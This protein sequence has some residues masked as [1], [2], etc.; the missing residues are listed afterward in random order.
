MDAPTLE[1]LAQ[2]LA[3]LRAR[4]ALLEAHVLAGAKA[5]K[6]HHVAGT[7]TPDTPMPDAPTPDALADAKQL[8]AAVF[9]VALAAEGPG[10]DAAFDAFRALVHPDRQGTPLL[11]EELRSYKWRPLLHRLHQYLGKANDPASFAVE[12]VQPETVTAQTESVKLYLRADK[13]MPP[14]VTLRRDP[15]AGGAWRLEA[16]SL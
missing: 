3:D 7:P 9:A 2:E 15:G 5:P 14:P 10:D 12:R 6:V 11:D 1:S 4:V 16:S 8:V 13:R